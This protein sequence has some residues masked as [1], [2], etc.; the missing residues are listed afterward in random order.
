M[1]A[2]DLLPSNATRLERDL[3]RSSDVLPTLGPGTQLIRTAKRINIPDDVVPWLIYEYGLGEI[4]PYVPD[5]RQALVEGVQWQRV[6]GTRRAVDIGLGWIG[7]AA[8]IEE[9]EAA[10]IRWAQ[11]QLG[12]NQAPNGLGAIDSVVGITRLSSPVRSQLFRVYGG[13]DYRRFRLDDHMLSEGSWLCDHTGTYPRPDWPQLSFG[14]QFHGTGDI[15]IGLAAQSGLEH[16]YFDGGIYEDRMILSCGVLDELEWRT[17]HLQTETLTLSRLHLTGWGPIWQDVETWAPVDWQASMDWAQL[18]NSIVP[19]RTFAK[20]GIYLSDGG[21]LGDT[22]YCFSLSLETETGF[23]ALLLSEG[24]LSTGEGILS[25]HVT[26]LV[27]EELLERFDR[28]YGAEAADT[29]GTIE[30]AAALR[31]VYFTHTIAPFRSWLSEHNWSGYGFPASLVQIAGS[32][33]GALALVED[34]N[35]EDPRAWNPSVVLIESRHETSS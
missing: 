8:E 35:A 5:L 28:S 3:S 15:S 30:A 1:T 6:R 10:T 11:F 22:N 31:Q 18:V 21:A 20:A 32:Q 27:V 17:W 25:Q 19:P 13:Y 9:S 14:R 29:R 24:D 4:T 2:A 12:L 7:F 34:T 23:S 16:V 33:V 26:Q